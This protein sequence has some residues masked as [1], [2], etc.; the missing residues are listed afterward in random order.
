[1]K[2]N[3]YSIGMSVAAML[4]V[5]TLMVNPFKSSAA[6]MVQ[7]ENAEA[8]RNTSGGECT[9][10]KQNGECRCENAYKCSDLTGCNS[11]AQKTE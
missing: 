10:P 4:L 9:G 11:T 2:K 3:I 7:A 1:M 8:L 5:L 6:D